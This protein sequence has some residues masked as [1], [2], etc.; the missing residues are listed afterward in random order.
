MAAVARVL[1]LVLGD[2]VLTADEI[3]GLTAG[4]LVDF[5]PPRKGKR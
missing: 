3:S 5:E 1:G 2:V 4:L